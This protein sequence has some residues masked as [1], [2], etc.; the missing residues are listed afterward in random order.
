[1]AGNAVMF[2]VDSLGVRSIIGMYLGK[3]GQKYAK[4]CI[5]P[6]SSLQTVERIGPSEPIF[7]PVVRFLAYPARSRFSVLNEVSGAVV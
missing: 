1:M 3:D 7:K 2:I 6:T 5:L 4:L